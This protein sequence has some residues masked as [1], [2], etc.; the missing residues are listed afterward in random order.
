[1]SKKNDPGVWGSAGYLM[2]TLADVTTA[3]K[4]ARN[5]YVVL[6]RKSDEDYR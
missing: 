6:R 3:A 4:C 1:M 5:S 2:A